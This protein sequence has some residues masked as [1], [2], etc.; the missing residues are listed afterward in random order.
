M[1]FDWY[2]I[3]NYT[4]FL[5]LDLPSRSIE[6]LIEGIGLKTIL[7]TKGIGVSII[8]E[9][10]ML[11]VELNDHNPFIFE[12]HAVFKDENNDLYLGIEVPEE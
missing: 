12:G 5:A 7:V 9:G 3:I 2:K 10:I 1:E 6:A 11:P 8:Y 4:E